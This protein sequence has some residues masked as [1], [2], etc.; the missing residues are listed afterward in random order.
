MEDCVGVFKINRTNYETD[1]SLHSTKEY[2]CCPS[3][4][5]YMYI[6]ISEL[7]GHKTVSDHSPLIR[8]DEQIPACYIAQHPKSFHVR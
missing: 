4:M 1:S 6:Y 2:L 8:A 5:S 7:Y 3:H